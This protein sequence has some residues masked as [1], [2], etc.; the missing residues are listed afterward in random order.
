MDQTINIQYICCTRIKINAIFLRPVCCTCRKGTAEELPVADGS[1]D[2]LTAASAAHWFDH[3]RFLT[4]A[5]RVL[6][7]RGCLSLLGFSDSD[8][9]FH[10]QNCGE[11]LNR[12]YE[13]VQDVDLKALNFICVVL[14]LMGN[15]KLGDTGWH[16][17]QCLNIDRKGGATQIQENVIGA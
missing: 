2:L 7:S 12:I 11:K 6:K 13:E 14:N 15:T 16:Y 9:K 1:V 3:S 10:Y 5:D 4:E 8:T 17:Y